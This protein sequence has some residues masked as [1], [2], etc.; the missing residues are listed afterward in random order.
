MGY[1]VDVD[2]NNFEVAVINNCQDKLVLIDFYATW[3]GPCKLLSPLLENL[4]KEYDFIV[5]KIDID[6]H[7]ELAK[8]FAVEGVPDVRIAYQGKIS[9]GFVGMLPEADIRALLE[10]YNLQSDLIL[11]L[12]EVHQAI[13]AKNATKVKQLFD[14][15]FV[16]YPDNPQLIFEVSTFLLRL[17]RLD[18]AEKMLKTISSEH[19]EYYTKA[20]LMQNL[21]YF[22][23][24]IANPGETDLDKLFFKAAELTLK[25][26]YEEALKIFLQIVEE[27]R[28]YRE[29]GAKKAMLSIFSLLGKN[30]PLTQQY[31]KELMIVLY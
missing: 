25:E 27:N 17:N 24:I 5:A 22:K 16:K 10:Q 14:E 9:P 26:D 21:I 3:C 7:P 13:E 2:E 30:N 11:K 29:D 12:K 18:E 20:Q 6:R 28:K 4:L 23:K 15:L 8:Q 19:T 31:Q 1:V